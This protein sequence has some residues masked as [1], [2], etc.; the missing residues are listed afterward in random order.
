[1]RLIPTENESPG[2]D[3]QKDSKS[4]SQE[5]LDYFP[6]RVYHGGDEEFFIKRNCGRFIAFHDDLAKDD[7]LLLHLGEGAVS[8]K[9]K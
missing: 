7:E 2:Y 8:V 1:M 5:V 4:P 9:L 3:D 6:L